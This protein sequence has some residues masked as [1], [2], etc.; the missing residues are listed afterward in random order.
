MNEANKKAKQHNR[1]RKSSMVFNKDDSLFSAST[2]GANS[3]RRFLE[4]PL[5]SAEELAVM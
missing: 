3:K 5:V 2:K 4:A 1:L